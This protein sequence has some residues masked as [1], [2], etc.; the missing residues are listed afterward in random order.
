MGGIL[1]MN[2]TF[3]EHLAEGYKSPSQKIR[4]MSES[5]VK[6]NIFCPCCGNA[7]ISKMQ[8]NVPLTDFCCNQCGEFFELKSKG[9]AIG[10][11]INDGAYYTTVEKI[12]KNENRDL[13]VLQYKELKVINLWIVPKYFF[14]PD[15]IEKRK[16]LPPTAK[17]AG[18]TGCN[19]LYGNIPEQGKIQ[20]VDN[21]VLIDKSKVVNAYQKTDKLKINNIEN[22][23][24][25]FSVLQ[26][27]N[28]IPQK[29]F[30]LK[31][32]YALADILHIKYPQNNNIQ[33]KI[34][35]QLQF[36]RDK[37]YIEFLD[38]KGHYRKI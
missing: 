13:F 11:K 28:S 8:N 21:S 36:L 6:D 37:G 16:P 35:Q 34:R 33:A 1:S 32:I 26:C 25:L 24:W 15:I 29:E 17:R 23:G 9:S 20:I 3:D 4:V 38:N 22:R 14:T 12:R 30:Y 27:I 7:K 31:D 2:M 5:W 18:W 10:K 19:I